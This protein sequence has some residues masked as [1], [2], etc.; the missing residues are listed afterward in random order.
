MKSEYTQFI[1]R[2]FSVGGTI[3]ENKQGCNLNEVFANVL[4]MVARMVRGIEC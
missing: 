3:M 1:F 2:I 4:F